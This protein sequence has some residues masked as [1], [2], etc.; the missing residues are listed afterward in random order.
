[1]TQRWLQRFQMR[2][3]TLAEWI[4]S[5]TI[6]AEGEP[7]YETDTGLYKIGDGVRR[8]QDLPRYLTEEDL[9]DLAGQILQSHIDDE[10][11]HPVYDNG[12]DLTLLYENAK[13]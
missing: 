11:P 4:S 1:M 9:P 7:G 13:V 8:W 12:P 6:L 3:G 5:G 10:T 2:R